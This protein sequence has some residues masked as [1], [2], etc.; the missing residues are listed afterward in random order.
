[1]RHVFIINP[2]SGVGKY[3]VLLKWL[4][5]QPDLKYEI[6]YTEYVGHAI[7]IAKRYKKKD[8]ILYSVGGDG[9]AHEVLNGL[10][11][12]VRFAIIP[13][14]TGNDFYRVIGDRKKLEEMIERTVLHGK[15]KWIDVGRLNDRLFLNVANIGIDAAINKRTNETDLKYIPNELGYAVS[16]LKEVFKIKPYN[17]KLKLDEE[18]EDISI[19][20]L[21][22]MNGQY[23]GGG[24]RSAPLSELD[25]GF[26]DLCIVDSV[27]LLRAVSLIP[28]Y[29]KGKHLDLK[30]V[31]YKKVKSLEIKSDVPLTYGTDGEIFEATDIKV[32]IL[33]KYCLLRIPG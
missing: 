28:K 19:T 15:D 32:E 9:T 26:L 8:T 33:E 20:L 14:G 17:F 16:A 7:E 23:Y 29:L 4:T 31:T 30:E 25:D 21:S 24:F 10:Q 18:F 1:M 27:S 5:Q 22:I 12:G 2:T 11:K 3:R 6:V 13:T